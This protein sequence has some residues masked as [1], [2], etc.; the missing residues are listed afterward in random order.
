MGGLLAES[1]MRLIAATKAIRTAGSM[2]GGTSCNVG[3]ATPLPDHVTQAVSGTLAEARLPRLG[4]G[5]GMC[6]NT[7]S[8]QTLHNCASTRVFS[9]TFEVSLFSMYCCNWNVV[10][11]TYWLKIKGPSK[12]QQ[13]SCHC[14]VSDLCRAQPCLRRRIERH[15]RTNFG[16]SK[17]EGNRMGAPMHSL[18]IK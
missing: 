18:M 2:K 5:G 8:Y 1:R 11:V 9:P 16:I 6:D 10:V 14:V 4:G 13:T 3:T 17:S 7:H 15:V 12:Y